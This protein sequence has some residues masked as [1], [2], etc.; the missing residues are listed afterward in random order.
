MVDLFAAEKWLPK[1]TEWAE[2]E[3]YESLGNL[4]PHSADLVVVLYLTIGM[5]LLRFIFEATIGRWAC[6]QFSIK[7]RSKMT[8]W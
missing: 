7:V 1:N 5:C 4:I 6:N 2:L 8:P 3:K